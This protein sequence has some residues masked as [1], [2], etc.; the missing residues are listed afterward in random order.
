M[1][2]KAHD[3][4]QA[5]DFLV[6]EN[7]LLRGVPYVQQ[8][9][10]EWEYTIFISADDLD[11]THRQGLRRVTLRQNQ[12]ARKRIISPRLI[13]ILKLRNPQQPLLLLAPRPQLP[14]RLRLLTGLNTGHNALNNWRIAHFLEKS[15]TQ[16]TSRPE[17]R[18]TG[19]QSLL[20][21]RIECRILYLTVHK[22]EQV[23]FYLLAFDFHFFVLLFDCFKYFVANLIADSIDVSASPQTAHRIDKGDLLEIALGRECHTNFPSFPGFLINFE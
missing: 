16:F 21:L 6:I 10:F 7:L 14:L 19:R 5:L 12:S 18:L 9:A 4:D 22:E 11:T 8:L 15:V 23:R 2:L 13:S 20:R 17:S 1:Q 3:L